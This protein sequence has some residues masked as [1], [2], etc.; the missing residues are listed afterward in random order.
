MNSYFSSWRPVKTALLL[1]LTLASCSRIETQ[2]DATAA[3][4][5][6]FRVASIEEA[7]LGGLDVQPLRT[8]T[9]LNLEGRS[10]LIA[11]YVNQRLPLRMRLQVSVVNP[12]LEAARL[13]GADY[14]VLIDEKL[15]GAAHLDA[16]VAVPA[17]DSVALPLIFELNTYRWLGKDALPQL[18]NFPLGLTDRRRKPP[19]LSLV[20]RPLLRG[21][22]GQVTRTAAGR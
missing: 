19:R 7:T 14:T 3:P 21:T 22:D 6:R 20:F 17:G 4:A 5:L 10:Q 11:G 13:G 15:L 9:D 1:S 8:P 18:R 16:D 12:G 2:Q